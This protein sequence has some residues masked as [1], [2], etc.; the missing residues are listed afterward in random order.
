MLVFPMPPR[1]SYHA[2]EPMASII[3]D[4]AKLGKDKE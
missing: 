2:K 4:L 1:L 3:P